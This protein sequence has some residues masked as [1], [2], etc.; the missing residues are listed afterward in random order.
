M[1]SLYWANGQNV[2]WS[3][4]VHAGNDPN[5][6]QMYVARAYHAG[7]LV[8][9]KASP[10][11]G[12]WVPYGG[13]EHHFPAGSN[14][15]VLVSHSPQAVQW[16]PLQAGHPVHGAVGGGQAEA[17]YICRV[18]HNGQQVP[19][20]TDLQHAWFPYGGQE[21]YVSPSSHHIEVLVEGGSVQWVPFHQVNWSQAVEAGYDQ[22]VG[23]LYIGRIQHEGKWVQGKANNGHLWVPYGGKE[24]YYTSSFEVLVK[25]G[26]PNLNWLPLQ[27]Y[28]NS[29]IPGGQPDAPLF[30][31]VKFN[32]QWVPGKSNGQLVWYGYGGQEQYHQV[33]TV[34]AQYLFLN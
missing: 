20:K 3:Q 26:S 19:G 31:R 8:Q 10:G 18:T 16:K 5:M 7:K 28:V 25:Q 21:H 12:A 29:N 22:N 9:G 32:G 13:Q 2:N 17:P 34:E 15:E 27:G 24:H 14:F 11:K 33:G 4:A 23:Q 6:G 30:T 1:S